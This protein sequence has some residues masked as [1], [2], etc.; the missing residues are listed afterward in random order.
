MAI[1]RMNELREMSN[2]ELINL[3]NQL[4]KEIMSEKTLIV[5]GSPP[6]NPGK[7]KEMKRTIAR[8]KFILNN[9]RNL[10]I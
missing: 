1:K 8:I 7:I 2:E 9:E 5:M 6:K 10:K 3:L 4:K